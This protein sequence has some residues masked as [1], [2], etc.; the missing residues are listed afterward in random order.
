MNN[1]TQSQIS[2]EV[3]NIIQNHKD[4]FQKSK[5]FNKLS[6]FK[7]MMTEKGFIIKPKYNIPMVDTVGKN[8]QNIINTNKDL[9]SQDRMKV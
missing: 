7:K 9:I 5:T 4:D 8:L 2:E 3:I 6:E 1:T